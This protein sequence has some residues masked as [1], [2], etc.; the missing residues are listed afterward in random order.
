MT[1]HNETT[2]AAATQAAPPFG[3]DM[4]HQ[5]QRPVHQPQ[6]LTIAAG[7]DQ[8]QTITWGQLCTDVAALKQRID[9]TTV[10][11]WALYGES[12][13]PFTVALLAVLGAGREVWLPATAAPATAD[14]LAAHCQGWL[15]SA[16]PAGWPIPVQT[17]ADS[18]AAPALP[19]LRG[20][21]LVYTSGSTG[22]PKAIS[23][24]LWQLSNEV[25]NLERLWGEQAR[26]HLI[27]GSVS[28]QHIY[29]L[30]F[31]VLW[32]LVGGHLSCSEMFADPAPLLTL[33]ADHPGALWISS[34][35]QLRRL[36]ADWHW[37]S[38]RLQSVFSSG[39][40]LPAGAAAECAALSGCWPLEVFGSSE[41]GGIGWRTQQESNTVWQPMPG[42]QVRSNADGALEVRS[43][44]LPDDDWLPMDDAVTVDA[45]GRFALGQRLDRIVKVEGKRLSLP[46]L[47]QRLCDH[48]WVTDARALLLKRHR[49]SVGVAAVLSESGVTALQDLGRHGFN[50][51]LRDWLRQEFE[52]VTLPRLWRYVAALPADAQGKV[53]QDRLR[54]LFTAPAQ[55]ILPLQRAVSRLSEVDV[56]FELYVDPGLT[57]FEGHFPAVPVVPGVVLIG[58]AD[59]LAREQL[60]LPPQTGE[61]RQLKFSQPVQPGAWL[62]LHLEYQK[63]RNMLAFRY[64]RADDGAPV[65]SGQLGLI[66][67]AAAPE[68]GDSN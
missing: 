63:R 21:I 66:A 37:S 19:A 40:P 48:D 64:T 60:D 56:R 49:E 42:I 46:A 55:G 61:V 58:W 30:L 12:A 54:A 34:P 44:Y 7:L 29:G 20:R 4:L 24:Q 47:E 14:R 8:P 50:R 36:Q 11:S 5:V 16:W 1:E 57:C 26:D 32:P 68:S 25:L 43:P 51:Q 31:R 22:E 38:A 35:A 52:P 10:P 27:L 59:Q 33:A 53:Q 17:A 39:G 6:F 15:G 23:K 9:D 18:D 45:D 28:H 65:A 13:Y 41:T 3:L 67:K 62:L 2:S